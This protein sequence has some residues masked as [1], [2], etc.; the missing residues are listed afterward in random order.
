M[1]DLLYKYLPAAPMQ[2]VIYVILDDQ[3]A[4]HPKHIL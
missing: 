3:P 4:L 2:K 1:M